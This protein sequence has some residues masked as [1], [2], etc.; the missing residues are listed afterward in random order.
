VPRPAAWLRIAGRVPL[1]LMHAL[2]RALAFVMRYGLHYRVGVARGNLARALPGMGV[3]ERERVLWLHYL[4]LA[5]VLLELPRLAVIDAAELAARVPVHG[6]GAVQAEL[7]AGRSVLLLTAHLSNWEWLLQA[8]AA[9]LEV[10]FL[11]AYKPPHSASADR[12]MLALRSRFGVRMIPAK[13][14]L[15]EIARARGGVHAVGMVADQMPTSSAGRL[16]LTFLGRETAFFP[17]PGE[18]ARLGKYT[19]FLMAQ[20]R[21]GAGRYSVDCLPLTAPGEQLEPAALIARYAAALEQLV[22]RH[23]EDWAWTHRRWKLAPP[24]DQSP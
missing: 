11:A 18:I 19:C 17:G 2:A 4:R 15:R 21:V 1:P 14:L 16:W 7:A 10:P 3:R 9:R 22:R 24:A 13:R 8:V 6:F 23:P 5:E 12:Q 20:R